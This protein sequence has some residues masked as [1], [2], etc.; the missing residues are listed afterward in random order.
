MIIRSTSKMM[1]Q[2][3]A[4][5]PMVATAIRGALRDPGLA[6]SEPD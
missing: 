6:I 2:S 3:A 4:T 5:I 1:G